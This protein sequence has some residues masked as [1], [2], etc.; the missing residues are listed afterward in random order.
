MRVNLAAPE[1]PNRARQS[2]TVYNQ[3][4]SSS[5]ALTLA[6]TYLHPQTRT[7]GNTDTIM[8]DELV[9]QLAAVVHAANIVLDKH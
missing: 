7:N 5:K 9:I 3:Y 8:H 4:S 1:T 6:S 2:S